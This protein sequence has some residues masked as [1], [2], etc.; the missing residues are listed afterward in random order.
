MKTGLRLAWTNFSLNP[1]LHKLRQTL[2]GSFNQYF[3][4]TSG[5]GGNATVC[6]P[7]QTSSLLWLSKTCPGEELA[8]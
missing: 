5:E 4:D 7:S 1:H 2:K 6:W 8:S 3:K